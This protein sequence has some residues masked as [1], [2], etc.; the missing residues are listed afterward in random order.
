MLPISVLPPPAHLC[1]VV[2]GQSFYNFQANTRDL[3]KRAF[4]VCGLCLMGWKHVIHY[5]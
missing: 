2:P 4:L 5:Q 3:V 1:W